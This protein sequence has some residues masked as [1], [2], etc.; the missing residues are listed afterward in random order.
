MKLSI[1]AAKGIPHQICRMVAIETVVSELEVLVS[2]ATGSSY[3]SSLDSHS[4]QKFVG[5]CTEGV[6]LQE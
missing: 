1:K 4:T 6:R 5:L 2:S 3:C